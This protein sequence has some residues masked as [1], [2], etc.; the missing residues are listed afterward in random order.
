LGRI[1]EEVERLLK[2]GFILTCHYAEWISNIVHMEKMNIGKIC[3]C[4]DFHNLNRATPKDECP[5]LVPDD[6]IYKA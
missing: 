6:L 3:V 2:A 4:V 5:M 1:K